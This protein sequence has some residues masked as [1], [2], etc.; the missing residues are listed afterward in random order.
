MRERIQFGKS[1]WVESA[2]AKSHQ[3]SDKIKS[4]KAGSKVIKKLTM[5]PPKGDKEEPYQRSFVDHLAALNSLSPLA[6]TR[7]V[8]DTHKTAFLDGRKPDVTIYNKKYERGE[9]VLMINALIVGEIKPCVSQ[10]GEFSDSAKGEVLTFGLRH[11]DNAP[12]ASEVTCF[13]TNCYMIQFFRLCRTEPG[14]TIQYRATSALSLGINLESNTQ[15]QIEQGTLFLWELLTATP[16]E[17]GC[18]LPEIAGVEFVSMIGKGAFGTVY[19]ASVDC[20]AQD[21][22]QEATQRDLARLKP[23]I[24]CA[25]KVFHK[26]RAPVHAYEVAQLR[27]LPR[28]DGLP[29]CLFSATSDSCHAIAMLPVGQEVR[30]LHRE[31]VSSIVEA[32]EAAHNAGIV[33]RDLKP[34]NLL[35]VPSNFGTGYG[36]QGL[37]IDWGCAGAPGLSDSYIGSLDYTACTI[38]ATMFATGNGLRKYEFTHQTDLESLLMSFLVLM[39]KTVRHSLAAVR[40]SR[41][42]GGS[43]AE[44]AK[45]LHTFWSNIFDS[46]KAE[47]GPHAWPAVALAHNAAMRKPTPD[48][49]TFASSLSM[50]LPPTPLEVDYPETLQK[51]ER[52]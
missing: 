17:L 24:Q 13:L 36:L 46:S 4:H 34:A 27:A 5:P 29:W 6:E 48:Y 18:A 12:H 28:R 25:L 38:L 41:H 51:V 47:S 21:A 8:I 33:H 31:H 49:K 11:L 30:C 10:S 22:T 35:Y 52:N 2:L 44:R 39:S 40:P 3:L 9:P 1:F 16:G 7:T 50:L 14:G 37:I 43:K 45:G 26:D 19:E 23:K 32:L 15:P 20:A 42:T